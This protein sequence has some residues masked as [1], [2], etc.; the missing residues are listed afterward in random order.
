V[1]EAKSGKPV[2]YQDKDAAKQVGGG[3]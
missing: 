1:L 2:E 3:K